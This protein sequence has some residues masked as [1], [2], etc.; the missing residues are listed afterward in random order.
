[1]ASLEITSKIGCPIKCLYCPQDKLFKEYSKKSGILLLDFST[2]K[3]CVDKVPKDIEIHFSGFSEPW[4]N[5]ECTKMVIY[6][7]D[8]GFSISVNTTCYG[9]KIRDIAQIKDIPFKSFCV[10]LPDDK[11]QTGMRVEG[12]YM[13]VLE[14]IINSKINNMKFG[15]HHNGRVNEGLHPQV[16]ALF[17]RYRIDVEKW[18]I[19][20]RAGNVDKN[21][22]R[23]AKR[24]NGA[25]EQCPRINANILLPNGD[26]VLCCADWGLKH[27]LGNL[28][29]S[30]YQSLFRSKVFCG[31]IDGLDDNFSDIL[32]RSCDLAHKRGIL[33]SAFRIFERKLKI[34][35]SAKKFLKYLK[36]A[37]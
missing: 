7:H 13:M 32:C 12:D 14:A 34:R 36:K 4:A 5:P 29:R 33:G 15:Y 19:Q 31:V 10:H 9:M 35:N 17:N 22:A 27:V 37:F 26:V 3:S 25:I 6:A 24:L 20:S 2:F 18:R 1:M 11:K 8:N 16:K 30:D 28:L 21:I 23:P